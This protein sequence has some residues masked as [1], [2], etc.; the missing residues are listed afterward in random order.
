MAR[1]EQE[2]EDL[3]REATALVER[4]E[5]EAHGLQRPI[6]A[7]FRR[8]GAASFFF[9]QELV[10]QF[11]VAGELRRGFLN[12]KLYK[13]ENGRLVELTR[14]RTAESVNLV[15]HELTPLET[16][17]FLGNAGAQLQKLHLLLTMGQFRVVGQAPSEG[18]VVD[19]VRDWLGRLPEQLSIAPSPRVR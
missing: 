3:L 16:A 4:V 1:E 2:R 9:G 10:Y 8:D 15:R 19:R 5:L 18:N 13:A 12:G 7:G 14:E 11:N 6:V 17:Q